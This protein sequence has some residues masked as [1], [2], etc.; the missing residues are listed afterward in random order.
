MGDPRVGHQHLDR[1]LLR[2]DLGE[3]LVHRGGVPHVA[4]HRGQSG[5][6]VPGPG[7]HGDLVAARREPAGDGQPDAPVPPGHEDGSAHRRAFFLIS[8][9]IRGAVLAGWRAYPA[10][11]GRGIGCHSWSTVLIRTRPAAPHRACGTGDCTRRG[12]RERAPDRPRVRRAAAARARR[13]RPAA[14]PRAGRRA[15]RLPRRAH[16]G[17]AD[18]AVRR[19]PGDAAGRATSWA[20]PSGW[21]CNGT[22]G[23]AAAVDLTPQAAVRA[24]EEAIDVAK[25]AAAMNTERIELAAEPGYG[26]V[27][28]VSAYEHGPVQRQRRRQAGPAGRL[29]RAA[30]GQPGDRP[31]GRLAAPGPGMQVLRRRRAPRP[32]SSGSGCTR[33]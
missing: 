26:D 8:K 23:F 21:C 2:L 30:A 5:D 13:G 3:R 7:G 31:R 9:S 18:R 11:G 22:W 14:G 15:R 19:P 24:A 32:P 29:E 4:G 10:G 25:V 27:S 20:W 17:P 28:W 1:P 12:H 6:G 33:C 16:P